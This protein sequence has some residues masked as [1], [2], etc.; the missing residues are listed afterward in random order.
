MRVIVDDVGGGFGMKTGMYAEDGAVAYCAK[1]LQR[2]VKWVADRSEEFLSSYH[3]RDI[4]T[5]AELWHWQPTA[6][7]WAC[8]CIPKPMWAPM[9]RARVWPS[10]C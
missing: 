8:V 7:F 9:P 3:G 10:S 4:Q 6:R 1:L 5:Q 2:P